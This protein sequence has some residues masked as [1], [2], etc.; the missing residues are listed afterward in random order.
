MSLP[1]D[2]KR[3]PHLGTFRLADW[4]VHQDEGTLCSEDQVLR[5]EPRVMDVLVY[6]AA[7]P[8]AVVSK[9][10]LLEV[11]WDGSFI[12]EGVL[13]QAIHS[14]RKALGDDA[15][16][17]RFI[18]TI[19]KRGY[20]L[21]ASV[22]LEVSPHTF[23]AVTKPPAHWKARLLL[24]VALLAVV[25]ALGFV[26]EHVL[27]SISPLTPRPPANRWIV[28]LPFENLNE[29]QDAYFAKALNKEIIEDLA[30]VTALHV[31]S[32]TS[33]V[34]YGG[35]RRPASVIGRELKVDY[36]LEGTLK[37]NV[38]LNG[39]P[40]VHIT[41]RLVRVADDAQVWVDGFDREVKDI[42]AVQSV[43]SRRVIAHL[44][45]ELSPEEKEKQ[46]RPPPTA[47]LEAYKTYLRG[48]ELKNQ[49]SYS[50]EETLK[51]VSMFE[52]ATDLDPRFAA[53]WSELSQSNCSLAFNGD[54]SPTRIAMAR[55]ALE[56]AVALEP[57]VQ[58]VWLARVYY[59]S[60]CEKDYHAAR[61][62]LRESRLPGNS[63]AL[64]VYGF[65]LRRQGLLQE[66]AEMLQR[67]YS[68][69]PKSAMLASEIA[70]TYRAMG[71]DEEADRFYRQAKSLAPDESFLR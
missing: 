18:Q 70:E 63:E 9:E 11:V 54:R 61:I 3:V 37:W 21:V 53:A 49:P 48:L 20:R 24:G 40:Q 71:N 57:D 52:H 17:P 58:S 36:V 19:P 35:D 29:P 69:D 14:L 31:I 1:R 43:I 68:L 65:I 32:Q 6:L 51:A 16:Q 66:A 8:G 10:E 5:L 22:E 42:F 46:F 33:A 50:K 27:E 47:N 34:H 44:G 55:K 23:P 39:V 38:G 26:P 30:S 28:V 45:V 41:P 13:A 67:A 64:R 62:L 2:T 56:R 15:R 60:Q 4:S 25:V 7:D 12:E 59:A